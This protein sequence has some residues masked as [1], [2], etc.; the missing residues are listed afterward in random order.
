MCEMFE[1]INGSGGKCRQSVIRCATT[2]CLSCERE[3]LCCWLVLKKG[4]ERSLSS[5]RSKRAQHGA[6]HSS[7]QHTL[8]STP[9]TLRHTTVSLL[10]SHTHTHTHANTV[11]RTVIGPVIPELPHSGHFRGLIQQQMSLLWHTGHPPHY[12][13]LK[14]RL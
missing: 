5:R 8:L 1:R 2:L 14:P 4:V 13:A 7:E 9:V 10:S 6:Q 3:V 11:A 12:I